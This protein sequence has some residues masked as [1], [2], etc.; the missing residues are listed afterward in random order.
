M[1]MFKKCL[2]VLFSVLTFVLIGICGGCK[3]EKTNPLTDCK[4]WLQS[5]KTAVQTMQMQWEMQ[6]GGVK[7]YAYEQALV[8]EEDG[9]VSITTKESK[10]NS[11][12]TLES[13]ESTDQIT[14]ADRNAL[15]TISLEESKLK[16]YTYAND[17]LNVSVEKDNVDDVLGW[18]K[19]QPNTD[20]EIAFGFTN[21]QLTSVSCSFKTATGK[22]VICRIAYAY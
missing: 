12:F 21:R 10:L 1:K 20:V 6:D 14:N 13:K 18:T 11:A 4:N 2:T 8:F 3:E 19:V 17:V 7:V 15:W 9:S 16:T 5:S 22:D